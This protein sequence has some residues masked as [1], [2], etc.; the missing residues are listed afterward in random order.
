[1]KTR[2]FILI[3]I[4]TIASFPH[5][6]SGQILPSPEQTFGFR[7]GS[8]CKLIDWNQ[9]ADYFSILDQGSD[10]IVVQELG[11]TT[12][13][14]PFL[15]AV[16]SSEDNIANLDRYRSIQ[17][18]LANPYDLSDDDARR[19]IDEGKAVVFV[20][21][22]IHS[23]EIGSSQ[24]SV[25]LAYELAT[26]SDPKTQ[27][28]LD[29]VI[30]LLIPSL[31]PDGLQMVVEW[32][33]KYVG[34][35]YEGCSMPYLYHHYAGHDNN[36]DWFFFNLQ[37]SR[38]TAPIL[39]REWFPQIVYDQHQMGSAG[40]RLFVPPYVDPVNLNVHPILYAEINMLGKHVVSDMHDQGFKGV[41]TGAQY[42]AF[43]EGVMARTPIWHNMLGILSEAASVRV[44]S[45][46]FLPRGSLREYG[47]ERPRYSRQTDFLDPWEGGWWRLRDIVDYEKAATYSI[48]DLAATYKD[49]FVG[50]F[51]RMNVDAIHK[52]K[53]E[54]PYAYIVPPDQ[55]DPNSATE[56]LKRLEF[57]GV[58]IYRSQTAFIYDGRTYPEKT[59]FIPLAQPCRPC[60]KDLMER[61]VYPNL[62]QYPGG[63][64]LTPYD[65]TGW[66]LPLQMGVR[67]VEMKTPLNVK[68]TPAQDYEFESCGVVNG[69]AKSFLVERRYNN[70]FAIMNDLFKQR[71]DL[72]WSDQPFSVDGREYPAG[73]LVIPNRKNVA[74][75][76]Q[77]MSEKYQVPVRG[78]DR[79]IAVKGSKASPPR[80]GIYQSWTAS[81]DEGWTRLVLDSYGFSYKPIHNEEI[82]AGKL[83]KSFDVIILPDLSTSAIVEGRSGRGGEPTLGTPEQPKEYQGGIGKEGVEALKDFINSGGTLITIENSTEFAIEKCRV[84]AVNVLKDM[85]RKDYFAPGTLLRI[86]LDTTQPLAYGMPK[87]PAIRSTT[88][89]AFRLLPYIRE[90]KA[91]G[92]FT[93]ENPL[94]SGWLI[95]PE[96]LEGNTVLAEIPVEKGRVILFGFGVQSRAQTFG[97]FKLLFNA[98][99]TSRIESVSS[100]ENAMQ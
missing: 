53:T 34:T 98:I 78:T 93:D 40:A 94:L 51:Y 8:D 80:L 81:M 6:I 60:I 55:H 79:P 61:Q 10:R 48:L 5:I 14:R 22:N 21:M 99:V 76:L 26:R 46:V 2:R 73:T 9:I 30:L 43:F 23:T 7:V 32:Y 50:N 17:Q 91:V 44:A 71:T 84:P 70:A 31:N 12:L 92:Y 20:S 67:V 74:S 11:K 96:K 42:N 88:S 63:P 45:P 28:I 89:P 58:N 15:L 86:E 66:T 85:N 24:E 27:K 1:M 47:P 82:K 35:P 25:E 29:N 87:H 72:F 38:L 62:Q 54:P 49:K 36:R 77:Q 57:N 64:P 4:F 100:L 97:T 90:S 56:M 18:R 59:I 41:V 3:S 65:F 13:G 39:Y 33:E 37:E 52:G 95:G 19:L 83:I 69:S 75:A 16:I 68:I